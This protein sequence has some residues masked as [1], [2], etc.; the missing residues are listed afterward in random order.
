MSDLIVNNREGFRQMYT[1]L[2]LSLYNILFLFNIANPFNLVS[3]PVPTSQNFPQ[4]NA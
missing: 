1:P 4:S 2:H 3:F